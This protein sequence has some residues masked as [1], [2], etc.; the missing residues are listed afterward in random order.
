MET[1][2]AIVLQSWNTGATDDG[3]LVMGL[4]LEVRP[5]AKP[6][7]QVKTTA[8]VAIGGDPPLITGQVVQV[9]IDSKDPARVILSPKK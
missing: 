7:Y 2:P 5:A 4:L 1:A 6:A 8:I 3:H 9:K